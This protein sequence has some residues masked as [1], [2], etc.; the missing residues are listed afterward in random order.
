MID[1]PNRDAFENEG[2]AANKPGY[3]KQTKSH[4]TLIHPHY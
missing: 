2:I 3:P 4:F 1:F